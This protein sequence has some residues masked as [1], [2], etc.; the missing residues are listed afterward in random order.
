MNTPK[1]PI[2]R[3]SQ[4]TPYHKHGYTFATPMR[5]SSSTPHPH[6][7]PRGSTI[8]RSTVQRRMVTDREAM[9]QLVDCVGMSAR[10]KVIESGRKPR[11]LTLP[12]PRAGGMGSFMKL[13]D[14]RFGNANISEDDDDF[15]GTREP[16]GTMTQVIEYP[17]DPTSSES[18]GPASPS[19]SPRPGSA[20]SMLSRRSTTPTITASHSRLSLGVGT[21]PTT[22]G[23]S[24][25]LSVF[26]LPP[27]P[28]LRHERSDSR[29]KAVGDGDVTFTAGTFDAMEDRYACMM[30]DVEDIEDRLAR[31]RAEAA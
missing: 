21:T 26:P 29:R 5:A 19:P 20:M 7:F 25:T 31:L 17:S 9:K 16:T 14:V 1:P 13:K 8:R 4:S 28:S 24:N 3:S 15:T 12:L 6:T 2:I 18:E 11:V 27:T 23:N 30:E 10:K 22:G